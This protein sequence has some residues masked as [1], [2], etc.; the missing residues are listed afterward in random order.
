[1]SMW[2]DAM[3]LGLAQARQA[4]RWGDVPVGAVVLAASGDVV[5]SA[6][7][8]RVL[9]G[10]PLAHAEMLALRRA[11]SVLDTWRLDACTLVVTLE[12]CS[13]CAGA[14][15][16]ARVGRLVYG[17]LDPKAGA[18]ASLFDVVRDPRL[19]HRCDVVGGILAEQ[20]SA[21]LADFFGT[22]R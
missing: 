17:A 5:A 16:Q 21:M 6:S 15:V 14:L 19:P 9:R 18:V 8:E 4:A 11:A 22:R 20:C 10:D 13:M 7:N 12:P 1:M 3:R 2:D